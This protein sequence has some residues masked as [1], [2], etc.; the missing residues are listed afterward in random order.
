MIELNVSVCTSLLIGLYILE[1]L[2]HLSQC[3][4]LDARNLSCRDRI[5]SASRHI[6]VYTIHI[7]THIPYIVL[8][9]HINLALSLASVWEIPPSLVCDLALAIVARSFASVGRFSLAVACT[10]VRS[11]D[12]LGQANHET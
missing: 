2:T 3:R 6:S 11:M 9:L 4:K 5:T 8:L 7:H 1:F 10:E 12:M